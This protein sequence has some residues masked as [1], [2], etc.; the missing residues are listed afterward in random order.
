MQ[1]SECVLNSQNFVFFFFWGGSGQDFSLFCVRLQDETE[2]KQHADSNDLT[3][4]QRGGCT[5]LA[6][7]LVP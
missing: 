1:V 6:R 3:E 5:S 2:T 4:H 7:D